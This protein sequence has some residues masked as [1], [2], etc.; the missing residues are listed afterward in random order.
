MAK[1]ATS[2]LLIRWAEK[3]RDHGTAQRN[4]VPWCPECK[5]C[6]GPDAHWMLGDGYSSVDS[7]RAF[8]TRGDLNQSN[9]LWIGNADI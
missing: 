7:R 5:S 2:F 3:S 9:I 6:V 1:K 4:A 8:V